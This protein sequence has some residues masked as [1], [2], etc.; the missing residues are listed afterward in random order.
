MVQTKSEVP[1][2]VTQNVMSYGVAH[3]SASMRAEW[4]NVSTCIKVYDAGQIGI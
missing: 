3:V 4:L 1:E 2:I